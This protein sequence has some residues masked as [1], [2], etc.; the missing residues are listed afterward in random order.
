MLERTIAAQIQKIEEQKKQ[1]EERLV[2]MRTKK[3]KQG[4][5]EDTKKKILIGAYFMEKY[6]NKMDELVPQLDRFLVRDTDRELFGLLPKNGSS[7][8]VTD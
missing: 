4:R 5:Y 8:S 3:K 1:L 2:S 7:Q 6:K